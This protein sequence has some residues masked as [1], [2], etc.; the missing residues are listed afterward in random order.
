MI[1]LE[2]MSKKLIG[3][4]ED[5]KPETDVMVNQLFWELDTNDLYFWDG[6]AWTKVGSV[7]PGD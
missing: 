7:T 1:T 6:E 5:Q 2:G 4:S 3:T